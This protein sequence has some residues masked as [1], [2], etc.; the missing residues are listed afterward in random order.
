MKKSILYAGVFLFTTFASVKTNAQAPAA[1]NP[2]QPVLLE[3]VTALPGEVKIAYEKYRLPNGLTLIIHEDHSDP[4]VHVEVTYHVGS[5]RESAGKSGFAHFFEHMMFQGSVHVKD[6]EH[7]KIVQG[8]GGQMNGT[9][10]RDRTNYFETMPANYLETALW[11]EADR[12]GYL[13]DSVTQKKFE[14]QRSTVKNEK[15]QRVDNVPYGKT[16]EIKDQ[17]LYPDRHPYSWPT[18]GYLED[19]DA[20]NVEDLKNFFMRWYGP[21]NACVVVAGDINPTE[22]LKL[23]EKYFNPI[24]KGPEV[25][26]M[27]IEPVRLPDN[28]YANYGDNVYLPL[29][30]VVF[31]SVKSF[32]PD[33]PALDILAFALGNGNNSIFYKNFVKT[34]KAVQANVFNITSELSGEFTIQMVTFPDGETDAETLMK[35]TLDEFEKNGINDDD[36]NRAKGQYETQI[37]ASNQSIGARASQLSQLWYLGKNNYNLNDE[38]AR[39]NKVTK[40]D[41]MRVFNQYIKGK[42][43]AMVN[44][45][46]KRT[47]AASGGKEKEETKA[48]TTSGTRSSTELEYKG[49]S[50]STPKDN[51]DRSKRPE[52]GEGKSPI[53]PDYFTESWDNGIKVIGSKSSES[54]IV[55]ILLSMKGGNVAVGDPAKTGLASLTADMMGEATQ[56]YTTEAFENELDKIGASINFNA[57]KNATIVQVSCL[58]KNLDQTLKLLEEKLMRPKFVQ[59]DFKLNQSQAYQSIN[60]RKTDATYNAD[61]AF[62][63]LV[64]GK[65]IYGEPEDGTL[66]SIKAL[67]VKDVQ[68]YYNQFYAPDFATLTIVGDVSKEEVLAKMAFMKNWPKKNVK[69]PVNPIFPQST[70]NNKQIYLVDK[71]K[72][73]QSEIRLGNLGM[74]YDWNDKYF[75]STAM[76]YPLGGSFNSR[77]NLNLREDKGFTYGI[78]SRYTAY[79]DYEGYFIISTSVRTSSTDSSMKEIMNEVNGFR[80]NGITDDEMKFMKSSI[81]Q[82]DALRYETNGQ[83]AGFLN[84]V[85]E[86]SLPSD[87]IKQQNGIIKNLTKEEINQMAKE[88]LNPEKMIYMIVGDKEKIQ[89]PLE[90]LGYKIVDYKEVEVATPVYQR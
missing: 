17:I 8:A 29:Y 82:S 32:H 72:A 9:T 73:A 12:M 38:I 80:E 46:P 37:I 89:K 77:L 67:T 70:A 5:A 36:L 15:G 39:Y 65:T 44:V 19:L 33:E 16:D 57:G 27:R 30:Y 78:N 52:V 24:P 53:V 83:K 81:T 22:V 18:I 41:V 86:L 14:V 55:N 4:I 25:K 34:E 45:F 40:E 21:N 6:E 85:V 90:K 13:L 47:N 75:K 68:T 56:N 2:N 59:E 84:R 66:K 23:T 62:S 3:K 1:V 87:Y 10:N 28:K 26:N 79:K 31:P 11:L 35:S 69:F 49:L 63:K 51:F 74:K 43:Y 60:S 42:N 61:L 50:Y 76:N 88:N 20:V 7:F 58:K 48:V 64:Y 54:P 71:Y